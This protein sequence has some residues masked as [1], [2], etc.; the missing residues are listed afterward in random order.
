MISFQPFSGSQKTNGRVFSRPLS[1]V[2]SRLV[3]AIRSEAA[4][5]ATRSASLRRTARLSAVMATLTGVKP[6]KILPAAV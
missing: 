6:V 3:S 4:M 2:Q 5:V 1:L